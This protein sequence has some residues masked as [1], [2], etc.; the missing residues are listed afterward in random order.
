MLFT[1]FYTAR[2]HFLPSQP[3]M[4]TQSS[5][6]EILFGFSDVIKR[7]SPVVERREDER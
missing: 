5:R 6:L 2:Q 7:Q 4:R 1:T 3:I